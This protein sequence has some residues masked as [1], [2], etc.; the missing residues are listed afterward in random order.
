MA[1]TDPNNPG[2]EIAKSETDLGYRHHIGWS[3]QNDPLFKVRYRY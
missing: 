2:G 1:L 3:W